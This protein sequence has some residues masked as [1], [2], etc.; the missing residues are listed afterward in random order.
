LEKIV[1][2]NINRLSVKCASK[3]HEEMRV[4]L[5][6]TSPNRTPVDAM[7]YRKEA[8]T[9]KWLDI[10]RAMEQN[11]LSSE[12]RED[13]LVE[14]VSVGGKNPSGPFRARPQQY[15]YAPSESEQRRRDAHI[16]AQHLLR[17]ISQKDFVRWTWKQTAVPAD[18]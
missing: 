2:N 8:I 4:K 12:L 5:M 18:A 11:D 3:L 6:S 10:R 14:S 13:P 15:Y 1:E 9:R 17:T 7:T 16:A